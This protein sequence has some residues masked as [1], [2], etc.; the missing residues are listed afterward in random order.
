MR[1]DKNELLWAAAA[2]ACIL[3][4]GS[5]PTWA[6]RLS[7][8]SDLHFRGVYF[9]PQDYAVDI[10]MMRSGMLGEWAYQF[11]FTAEP[12]HPAYVRMFYVALG[13]ISAWLGLA[14]ETAY[15]STRWLFGFAALLLLYA[16]FRKIFSERF[17]ARVGFLL[18]ALGSGLGWLQL[19]F[20]WVPGS[21]T[22]IDFWLIDVYIFFSLSLFPHFAFALG[23]MCLALILWLDYLET[24]RSRNIIWIAVTAI[25]V[26][27]TNP[28][29]FAVVDAG[30]A[31]ATL[32]AWWSN[33]RI[34]WADAGALMIVAL[35]QIPLF[36]YN[37]II[38]TKDPLW[39]QYTAQNQ[40]LSPP[41]VY[42]VW[43]LAL[44]LPFAAAGIVTAF[45]RKK[46]AWGGAAFWVL[47]AFPLAYAPF[48]IQRRFLLG[49]TIPL[50]IL[51]TAGL[52]NLFEAASARSPGLKR[53][54]PPLILLFISF[55]SISSLALSLGRARFMQTHPADF[56]YPAGIDDAAQ[57]LESHA[58]PNDVAL[59][60]EQTAQ[61]IAQKTDLRVYFGHEMETLNFAAKQNIV[62]AFYEGKEPDDWIQSTPIR[63]VVY[64]PLE[65]RINPQFTAAP[66]LKLAYH[67]QD[68]RIFE[69]K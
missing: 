11:R 49:I 30:F 19:I 9:D 60:S 66:N 59:A 47:A 24:S 6:G 12:P 13:H 28:I 1:R 2:S 57:W 15:E 7:Q 34:R 50:A 20:H 31:G 10:S 22:P 26:Q 14:P 56:F 18:A 43:G 58:H 55:A 33:R 52:M 23:G 51:A 16:L 64:G 8:T 54:R 68:I 62:T 5:I 35:V 29:A 69:V 63:W 46:A 40:T 61:V 39:S 53:W 45:Q 44:F 17:W 25:L 32:F 65:Q 37:L 4:L 41:L 38:L 48:P 3:I 42:Y 27:F 21:I 67:N 36:L